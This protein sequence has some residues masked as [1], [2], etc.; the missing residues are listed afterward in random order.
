MIHICVFITQH[1][2]YL[3]RYFVIFTK[4]FAESVHRSTGGSHSSVFDLVCI[5]STTRWILI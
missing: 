4:L 2:Q 1:I 5:V 3:I